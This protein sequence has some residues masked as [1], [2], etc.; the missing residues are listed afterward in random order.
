MIITSCALLLRDLRNWIYLKW[1]IEFTLNKNK[2]YKYF[3][4]LKD[5]DLIILL[6]ARLNWMLHF[7]KPPRFT[8]NVKVVQV[9]FLLRNELSEYD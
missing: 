8:E 1:R 4:A 9:F 5:S 2:T 6:G 3:R 7:G